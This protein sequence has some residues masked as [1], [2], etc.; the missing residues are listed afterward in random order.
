MII[1]M[2]LLHAIFTLIMVTNEDIQQFILNISLSWKQQDGKWKSIIFL[3]EW[4]EPSV[5]QY[6]VQARYDSSTQVKS[7]LL[8]YVKTTFWNSW[9][10]ITCVHQNI[11]AQ[12]R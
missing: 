6:I 3:Q 9:V 5:F 1:Y 12:M 7:S 10:E 11:I 4:Y 2:D 8:K